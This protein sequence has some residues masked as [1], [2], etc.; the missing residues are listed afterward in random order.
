MSWKV[1]RVERKSGAIVVFRSDGW[2][3]FFDFAESLLE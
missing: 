3:L 2:T 1:G